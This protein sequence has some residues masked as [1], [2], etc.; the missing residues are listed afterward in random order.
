M[1]AAG[2]TPLGVILAGGKSS[3]MGRDKAWLSFFGQPLLCRVAAVVRNVVGELWVSGRDP[4]AF[5]IDAPWLPDATPGLGPA[6]GILT[7][8][9][10]VGRSCL[11]VSCDLPFLDEATLSRLV[12]AWR[13]RPGGAL[14]TTFRIVE[15][16]Y[17]E[18]LVAV[19]DPAG[20]PLLRESLGRG[21]RRLSGIFPE[22]LRCH[23]DYSRA[24]TDTARP[25][26]NVNS[27]PD[28]VLA[29]GMETGS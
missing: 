8:L 20:L 19:Y 15:T 12:A 28:L 5:G 16:G 13:G 1:S 25:F 14:M 11:V 24:D 26:F 27:P 2:E 21:E 4:S 9:E 18:S 23:I 3:R 10:A 22:A 17:V 29:R 7:V 6:G